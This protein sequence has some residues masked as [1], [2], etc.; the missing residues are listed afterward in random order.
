[1]GGRRVAHL[2]WV[3][4]SPVAQR[5]PVI[6]NWRVPVFAAFCPPL[7]TADAGFMGIFRLVAA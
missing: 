1:M 2:I 7:M 3:L 6:V 4:I 5:D